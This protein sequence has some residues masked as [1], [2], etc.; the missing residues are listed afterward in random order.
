M[1]FPTEITEELAEETGWHIGDGSMNYYN[2]GGKMKGFYS[3]RGHIIDDKSHYVV[4]IKPIFKALYDLDI[5]IHDMPI[6]SVF[7]FQTWNNDLV[8]FKK[9]LGLPLGPKINITIPDNFL[10]SD[11]LKAAV[12]R[13]IFDTDG[14]VYLEHRKNKLYPSLQFSTTS[15]PLAKQVHEIYLALGL[16]ATLHSY[17]HKDHP[18]WSVINQVWI[19]GD[20]MFHKFMQII[21]PQNPKHIA[22]YEFYIKDKSAREAVKKTL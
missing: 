11:K 20:E 2:N 15:G 9:S 5:A 16:R 3:L 18:K 4:R 12:I 1:K 8:E 22:K 10:K 6:T 17:T 14:C 13:G 19:R 21:N 7:G